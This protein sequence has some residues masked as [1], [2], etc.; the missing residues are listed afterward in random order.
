[1]HTI[2]TAIA[3][4]TST[5]NTTATATA[6]STSTASTTSTGAPEIPDVTGWKQTPPSGDTQ[7][8]TQLCARAAKCKLETFWGTARCIHLCKTESWA[9][10]G[11]IDDAPSC[12][13]VA[14]CLDP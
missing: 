5:A 9:V 14:E 8:C 2:P 6:T 7:W 1:M 4:S 13:L 10:F 12:P 11:C 3:T